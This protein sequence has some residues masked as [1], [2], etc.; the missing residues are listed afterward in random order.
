M[1]MN[2]I[3]ITTIAMLA[4]L[5]S[6]AHAQ[7]TS[8]NYVKTQTML[9]A[10]GT[11][12]VSAVQYY[13]GFGKPTVLVANSDN[14]GGTAATLTTY[15]A[16][17]R[18]DRKYVPVPGSGLNY[19]KKS[20]FN[21]SGYY[22]QDNGIFT[23]NHYDALDRV[24]AVDIA[25]DK[26]RKAGKQNRT[27]FLAN[28][29]ADYVCIYKANSTPSSTGRYY[30]AGSLTKEIAKDADNK[31]VI[32]FKNL[33]GNVI[34]QRVCCV[35]H[36]IETYY[37]Y[38]EI[39]QLRYVLTPKIQQP[40]INFSAEYYYEY[41]YD[42]RGRVKTKILPGCKEITY[43][44][45]KA[46]RIAYMK[47]PALGSRYRFYLYDKLGRLCVQGTC[48]DGTRDSTLLSTTSYVSGTN[49]GIC[50]TGYTAPYTISNPKLEIVNYYDNYNFK[51]KQQK[52][53]MPAVTV[54]DNQKQY[55]IGSLTG[56]VVYATNGE[57]LGMVNVYDQKGQVVRSVRKGLRGFVEDVNTAYTFTGDV[58]N[59][60]ANVNVK[61]GYGNFSAQTQYAYEYGKKTEM[62][63]SVRHGS[64]TQTRKTEYNYD[65][66]GRLTSKSRHLEGTYKSYCSYTYDVHGW[67]TY[68]NSGGFLEYLYY[69][70]TEGI[71]DTK[72]YNGNISAMR[73]KNRDDNDYQGYIFKYD[74]NNRLREAAYGWGNNLTSYKNYF[75]EY[76]DEYDRNGN[77]LRLRRRG[78]TD[79]MHGGFGNVDDLYMTYSGNK[80]TKVRDEASRQPY[81][82]A[83]DFDGV[84]G[85]EYPLKYNNA[86]SLV[87]DAGR[88]IAK[89]QYD[90]NNNPVR[91]QFT[92]G[93]VTKYVYSATGEKLRVIYQTSVYPENAEIVAIG[94][95]KELT[96]EEEKCTE[97]VDYLL[98]GALTLRNGV[99]DKY[100][101]EEGYCQATPLYWEGKPFAE[102]F[103]FCYYDQDH[104]GNVRQVT[105]DDGSK[106]G[107]VI[108]R[109]NYYPFGAEFCD[110]SSKSYVQNHK[111][112][113][114]EFDNMHGLNTYDYGARQ[115]NP[116]TARWDR[117]DPL[118][119]K[120]YSTS[121]YAYCRN[122]PISRIDI[123]GLYDFERIKANTNHPAI[124]VYQESRDGTMQKDYQA[125]K[126]ASMPIVTVKNIADM[127]D[128]LK[129]MKEQGTTF[130]CVSIN[131]HGSENHFY[132]GSDAVT[133][134]TDLSGLKEG[135]EGTT[136]F[137]GACNVGNGTPLVE[138]VTEQT[139][140]TIVAPNQQVP[141][142][143]KY[144]GSNGLTPSK[145]EG[146][147]NFVVSKGENISNVT[148][149]TI[150]KDKGINWDDKNNETK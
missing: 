110:N 54:N 76:V 148:N 82:G 88:K 60:T 3:H 64:T 128:A 116:V 107:E 115:Y 23:Q 95:T 77:I 42:D 43:W 33:F 63:L 91:I 7:D 84:K 51:D 73:W 145:C 48:T 140:A 97:T 17:G 147:G 86:G 137:I 123:D 93:N 10:E 81:E 83:T 2:K 66:T 61:Y 32:T 150:D 78:L 16:L 135:L 31:T 65:F 13:N 69:A 131:S 9:N 27:E 6:P 37:V 22:Y 30:P 138:Q 104:L 141:A 105:M 26:W 89:I 125:A 143:Y 4:M 106:K 121:S 146:K 8:Q 85:K 38:N 124:A 108:Q 142:G 149:V 74:D 109:M 71:D 98:G 126:N 18:E 72:Y 129:A 87:S 24:T 94:K 12:S 29:D 101:F 11:K 119:E 79:K 15:D 1:N 67:L 52:S 136:V 132:I 139:G 53:N 118:C 144:D 49:N 35:D 92:N 62:I 36:T 113:G 112:N 40:G 130:D 99:I 41:R 127:G 134:N 55:S 59:T 50:K 34:L 122:N 20:T 21:S 56:T 102:T 114:K 68:I 47:D 90:S 75:S 133:V 25:G 14:K 103:T 44:Y 58:D 70:D 46:D 100:Q 45:D 28:T 96:K 57:A 39:G 111:Y 19:I 117:M 120:Y 5:L 80:L